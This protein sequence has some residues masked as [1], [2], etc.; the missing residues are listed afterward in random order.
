MAKTIVFC[1]DGT[2][3]G[4]GEPDEAAPGG[5]KYT[6]VLKFY[7]NLA[8]IQTDRAD[9]PEQERRLTAP[10]GTVA[11]VA[12]YL[13]GVGNSDSKVQRLLEG[14]TGIGVSARVIRGYTFISRNFTPGDRIVLLGFSRGAYTA[15]ALGGLIA[16]RGLLDA[17]KL[18]LRDRDAAYRLGAQVWMEHRD[19][20]VKDSWLARWQA[21]AADPWSA[22]RDLFDGKSDER[23]RVTTP[24]AAIGVW[25]T[26]GAM[27]IPAFNMHAERIDLFQ[28]ADRRLHA[29]VGHGFHAIAID[30]RRA[31]FSPTFWEADARVRQVLFPGAHSDV[32]GGYPIAGGESG[33]S[34][35][36]LRWMM[37]NMA[38]P[39]IEVRFADAPAFPPSPDPLGPGHEPWVDT[40]LP[41]ATRRF[42]AGFGL[43]G[44]AQAR[45]QAAAARTLPRGRSAPYRPKGLALYLTGDGTVRPDVTGE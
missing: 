8:G 33:L 38:R 22:V 20:C 2:W 42:P 21:L 7:R 14:S 23:L 34:D 10:D 44:T 15:R 12:K 18:N 9:A 26:V 6:N 17:R 29:K 5:A 43:S 35:G 40:L 30:E 28:F 41:E 37:D 4:A 27:G 1:A 13:H 11:Q 16:A 24:I 36:A 39:G 3:N 32:G 25:D 45:L 31:D 19:A